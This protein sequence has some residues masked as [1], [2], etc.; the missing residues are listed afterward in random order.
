MREQ[1]KQR[2]VGIIVITALLAIFLPMLLDE[3]V[4][5]EDRLI[6]KIR[7]PDLPIQLQTQAQTAPISSEQVLQNKAKKSDKKISNKLQRWVIQTGSFKDKKNALAA[8]DKFRKQG[9]VAF[10]ATYNDT[11]RVRIGP[12]L[13][14]TKAV[15]NKKLLEQ[16]NNIKTL[17]ILQ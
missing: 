4:K 15:Q 6:A 8:Q 12:E 7:I 9:F 10:V 1:I 14:K 17:L 16:Q 3:P 13:N 5:R 11:Y 2:L